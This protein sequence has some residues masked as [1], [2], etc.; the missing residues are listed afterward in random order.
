[1]EEMHVLGIHV[2]GIP[3]QYQMRHIFQRRRRLHGSHTGRNLVQ[4][5]RLAQLRRCQFPHP[6]LPL[7]A[8][9]RIPPITPISNPQRRRTPQHAIA[10]IQRVAQRG[11]GEA[12]RRTH[13]E[14]GGLVDGLA[15]LDQ[16][17][18]DGGVDG[19]RAR[20]E[21]VAVCEGLEDLGG[22]LQP[23]PVERRD[24]A[25]MPVVSGLEAVY[26]TGAPIRLPPTC[27]GR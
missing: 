14:V 15:D 26:A 7:P 3:L 19:V 6:V 12:T 25:P 18:E 4:M 17:V 23:G 11:R 9:L 13:G 22:E 20:G 8:Q 27:C 10:R 16:V 21:V 2:A 24:I 1:M 5:V